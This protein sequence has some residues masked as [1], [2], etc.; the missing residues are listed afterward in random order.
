MKLLLNLGER[1]EIS[2]QPREDIERILNDQINDNS[3]K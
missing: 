3:Q 1:S 2:N